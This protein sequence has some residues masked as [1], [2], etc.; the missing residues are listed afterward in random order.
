MKVFSSGKEK[1]KYSYIKKKFAVGG[2][3]ALGV[4]LISLLLLF[5]ALLQGISTAGNAGVNIG[6]LGISSI[7]MALMS[8]K[9]AVEARREENRNYIFALISGGADITVIL[10]WAAI[11]IAGFRS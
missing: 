7:L 1:K 2:F 11:I 4:T 10:L 5:F 8:L 3:Y 6:A 9:F